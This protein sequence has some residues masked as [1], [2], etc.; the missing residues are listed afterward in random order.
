MTQRIA[1]NDCWGG[2][3]L[4]QKA[5]ERLIELGFP[6]C[7]IDL[8]AEEPEPTIYEDDRPGR[9]RYWRM[10]DDNE[11]THPLLLQVIN[12]LGDEASGGLAKVRIV[13][14]PDD[15]EWEID[16]YDGMESVHEQHRS[17]H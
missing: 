2:F 11:R 10:W 17:W 9:D 14:V 12:E 1:I 15:V 8:D 16:D 5:Y 6:V 4:S 3:G 7:S 13:T